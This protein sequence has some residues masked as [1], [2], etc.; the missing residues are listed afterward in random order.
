MGKVHGESW[1]YPYPFLGNVT[2]AEGDDEPTRE[3]LG[4]TEEATVRLSKKIQRKCNT[5]P[6]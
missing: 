4:R 1:I 6:S 2:E 5:M 3:W